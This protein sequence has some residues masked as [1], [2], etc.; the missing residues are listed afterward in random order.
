MHRNLRATRRPTSLRGRAAE[1]ALLDSLVGDLRRGESRSLVVHGEAGIGKTAL[2]EYLVESASGMTVARAVG[3]ESEMELAYASL[4]QICG[5]LLDRLPGLPTPQRD[6]LE[7]VFGL[8]AGA[9]PDRF[10]VGLGVLG[11]LS[12]VGEERAFLCVVDDAQW[13][14]Q[15]SALTLAFVAR[16][17]RADPVGIVFAA[18]E[19]GPELQ[20][21]PE[22]EVRGVRDGE[23]RAL[24]SSAVGFTLDEGVRDRIIAETRGNPLA[25]LE[26]PQGLT[27][28]QLAGGF[29]LPDASALTRR[30]EE[31]FRRRLETFAP[32]ARR[33]LLVAAAEPVGDPLLLWRAAQQLGL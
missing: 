4:H 11:L 29:G 14:D 30:I 20:H 31:S 1:C 15:A 21:L 3:V 26:L 5:P 17:L 18:R 7:V 23:A 2:L 9:G 16:R 22:L 12:D 8:R 27:A 10:L 24:L 33:L 19:P 28:T 13:L 32:D 25:L 6:A